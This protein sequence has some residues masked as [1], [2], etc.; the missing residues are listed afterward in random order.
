MPPPST[1]LAGGIPPIATKAAIGVGVFVV[2]ALLGW[3]GR[4]VLAGPPDVTTISAFDDWRLI[5]PA[6]KEKDASCRMTQDVIDSKS[7]QS[8]ASLVVLKEVDKDKKESTVLAVNVPLNVLLEPGLGLKFGNEIKTY[9]YKTCT[10][11]GCVAVV[12]YDDSIQASLSAAGDSSISVARLDGK[13]IELPFSTKGF[14]DARKAFEHF[15]AKRSSWWWR[16]WS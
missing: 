15:D 13:T 12:P 3:I 9:Q 11:G 5:C 1:R 16:L 8:I 2:G 6:M 4:G 14:V 7:G 10:E